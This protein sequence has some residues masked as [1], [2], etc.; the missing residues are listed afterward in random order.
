MQLIKQ[1]II[2]TCINCNFKVTFLK[3]IQ[4]FLFWLLQIIELLELNLLFHIAI[5]VG[6][7]TSWYF[8][9]SLLNLAVQS[10]FTNYSKQLLN[11]TLKLLDLFPLFLDHKQSLFADLQAFWNITLGTHFWIL[12]LIKMNKRLDNLLKYFVVVDLSLV[13][14]LR[15]DPA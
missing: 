12:W 10:S 15:F 1:F 4:M 8:V 6:I 7:R 11:I 13:Q 5:K 3:L 9:I 14:Y 2:F